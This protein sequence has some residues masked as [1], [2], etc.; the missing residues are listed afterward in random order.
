[1]AAKKPTKL[2][3]QRTTARQRAATRAKLKRVQALQARARIQALDE[4]EKKCEIAE[5][6]LPDMVATGHVA[7]AEYAWEVADHFVEELRRRH[8][9]AE[10]EPPAAP[11]EKRDP[12]TVN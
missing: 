11:P 9:D 12:L 6:L 7:P 10:P 5:M 8:P 1:M 4:L 3:K 2:T